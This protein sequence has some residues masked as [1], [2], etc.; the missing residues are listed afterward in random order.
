MA[1][2]H[3]SKFDYFYYGKS[4]ANY[5]ELRKKVLSIFLFIT[6]S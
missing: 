4:A 6:M 5:A 3:K 1:V 2:L